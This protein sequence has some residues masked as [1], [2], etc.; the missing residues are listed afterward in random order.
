MEEREAVLH[1]IMLYDEAEAAMIRAILMT[2][3]GGQNLG[4]AHTRGKAGATPAAATKLR[5]VR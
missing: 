4:P 1:L 2:Q 5:R 3:R